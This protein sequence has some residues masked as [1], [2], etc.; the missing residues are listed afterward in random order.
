MI[1]ANDRQPRDS[2]YSYVAYI[3]SLGNL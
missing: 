2:I 3:E 1:M